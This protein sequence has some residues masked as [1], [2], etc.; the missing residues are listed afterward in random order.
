[1]KKALPEAIEVRFRGVP[2]RG[3]THGEPANDVRENGSWRKKINAKLILTN[4]E[5]WEV[6]TGHPANKGRN[7]KCRDGQVT[8]GFMRVLGRRVKSDGKCSAEFYKNL[9]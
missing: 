1:M 8:C 4:Q 2:T 9:R 5:K 3:N 7:S 6:F